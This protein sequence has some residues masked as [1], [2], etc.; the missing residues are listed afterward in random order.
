VEFA[1]ILPVM[2]IVVL[3]LIEIGR[4]FVFG[5]GV[6]DGAHQAARLAANARLNPTISD[7]TVLQRLL[8]GSSPAML[9]CPDISPTTIPPLTLNCGGGTWTLTMRVTPNGSATSYP[10]LSALPSSALAQM[11]GGRVEAKAVG[12]VSLLAGFAPGWAGIKLQPIQVQGDA[13]M[14]VL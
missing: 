14:V 10:S 1:L 9:G 11:N 5:V 8:D 4:A 6:Q 2:L 7:A 13:V 12:S 3:G